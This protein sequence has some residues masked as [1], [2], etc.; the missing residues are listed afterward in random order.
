MNSKEQRGCTVIAHLPLLRIAPERISFREFDLWQMPFESYSSLAGE[1]LASLEADYRATAP[2]FLHF[3]SEMDPRDEHEAD[4]ELDAQEEPSPE[5][6]D[7]QNRIV[8]MR[9]QESAYHNL[10]WMG[11]ISA[12]NQVR[13]IWS[14]LSLAFPDLLLPDPGFSQIFVLAD[15][16]TIGVSNVRA[17]RVS[18]QGPADYEY[19]FLDGSNQPVLTAEDFSPFRKVFSLARKLYAQAFPDAVLAAFLEAHSPALGSAERTTMS[20]VAL[21]A[22]VMPDITNGLTKTF[23]KRLTNLCPEVDRR[24]AR[25]LYVARSDEMHATEPDD[26]SLPAALLDSSALR[27]LSSAI[28]RMAELI[29]VDRAIHQ[30][31]RG[32]DAAPAVAERQP[33][34]G[35]LSTPPGGEERNRLRVKERTT[36][37]IMS[38]GS[39][40]A[41][42]GDAA[43]WS[44]LA[45]LEARQWVPFGRTVHPIFIAPLNG[46]EILSLEEKETRADYA[47]QLR[48]IDDRVA[49][50]FMPIS[51]SIPDSIDIDLAD[52]QQME[53][54]MNLAARVRDFGT[55]ALRLAQFDDFW[56]PEWHGLALFAGST[57]IRRPTIFRQSV[58]TEIHRSIVLADHDNVAMP[59][60]GPAHEETLSPIWLTLSEFL[61]ECPPLIERSLVL[62]RRA[63]DPAFLSDTLRVRL[64]YAALESMLGRFS[65]PTRTHSLEELV[66]RLMRD[67]EPEATRW[68][69]KAGRRKRNAAAHTPNLDSKAVH[70]L[71]WLLAILRP[72]ILAY[73]TAWSDPELAQFSTPGQKLAEWIQRQK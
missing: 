10:A 52:S 53:S 71:A 32:L 42:E 14:L 20:V 8:E 72:A 61:D 22:L 1:N 19:L 31:R 5:G 7:G 17:S 37:V 13:S 12:A 57:R 39:L 55:I 16:G 64:A 46:N 34:D 51:G 48:M 44:P 62:F 50:F 4:P 11:L 47:A 38:Q 30:V 33:G 41:K 69:N 18:V 9:S 28:C 2:V 6:D 70:E 45:R 59:T 68:F 58:L 49:G 40:A 3:S 36:V 29:G 73:L 26:Q 15:E 35:P 54:V 27:T 23:V 21:E 63:S 43:F 65:D 66:T 67:R 60:V 24:L 25:S 56:D